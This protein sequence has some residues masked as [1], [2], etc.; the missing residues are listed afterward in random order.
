MQYLA[1]IF[2]AILGVFIVKEKVSWQQYSFFAV[3][4]VGVLVIQGFDFRISV[5][6][7]LIGVGAAF[8]SGLAYNFVRKLNTSEH[9][10]GSDDRVESAGA[11][12]PR[13]TGR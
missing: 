4:F 12:A 2:T 10:E 13:S 3:S 7:L 6:Q 5:V 11:E 9:H 1:P 8:F